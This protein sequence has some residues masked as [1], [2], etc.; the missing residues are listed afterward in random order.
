MYLVLDPIFTFTLFLGGLKYEKL[1]STIK[2][3]MAKTEPNRK[4]AN[5][6]IT[7]SKLSDTRFSLVPELLQTVFFRSGL[8]KKR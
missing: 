3:K 2:S 8:V 1:L 5:R 6:N 4:I 7:F